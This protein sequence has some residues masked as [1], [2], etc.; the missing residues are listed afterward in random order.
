MSTTMSSVNLE[1][2][3]ADFPG[4][5]AAVER[6]VHFVETT[7][8][9]L[10]RPKVFKIERI[11]AISE[12]EISQDLLLV[13]AR[14]VKAGLLEQ[15]IRVESSSG[16]GLGDYRSIAEVPDEIYDW[17]SDVT[18]PVTPDKLH[19]YYKLQPQT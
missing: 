19:L 4:H 15:F 2:L 10:S 1:T 12:F 11:S 7:N 14:L 5:K 17:R 13:L 9:D 8:K 18:I 6:L 16:G 3:T